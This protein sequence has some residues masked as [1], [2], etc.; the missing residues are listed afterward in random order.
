MIT[1]GLCEGLSQKKFWLHFLYVIILMLNFYCY[2]LIVQSS[3]CK[4]IA[5][6]A[7]IHFFYIIFDSGKKLTS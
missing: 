6:Y 2:I 7:L 4:G 3:L 1:E 5:Q